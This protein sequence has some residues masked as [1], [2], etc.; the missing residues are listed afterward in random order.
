MSIDTELKMSM[1]I[2]NPDTAEELVLELIESIR[3]GENWETV[4]HKTEDGLQVTF[5][6]RGHVTGILQINLDEEIMNQFSV[7]ERIQ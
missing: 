4:Y 1:V 2:K 3:S 5:L 6:D 7:I